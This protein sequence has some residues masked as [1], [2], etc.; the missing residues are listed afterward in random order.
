[1][2]RSDERDEVDTVDGAVD[3]RLRVFGCALPRRAWRT[4]ALALLL[5]Q[6]AQASCCTV[7]GLVI[8]ASID[9]ARPAEQTVSPWQAS[10]R[11]AGDRIAIVMRDST[12]VKGAIA[13]SRNATERELLDLYREISALGPP[14]TRLPLPEDMLLVS[15]STAHGWARFDRLANIGRHEE[16]EFIEAEGAAVR[17]KAPAGVTPQSIPLAGVSSL[18]WSDSTVL[19]GSDLARLSVGRI[20]ARPRLVSVRIEAGDTVAIRAWEIDRALV[21]RKGKAHTIG[22]VTGLIA[23]L[24]LVTWTLFS[25]RGV[26][27]AI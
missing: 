13:G 21:Y 16:S 22:A 27:W 26:F 15:T 23:D 18:Q 9:A 5:V 17:F 25:L 7:A 11:S 14:G 8:G 2:S 4:V 24:S 12:V 6:L 1:V 10:R 20:P 19:R 3:R